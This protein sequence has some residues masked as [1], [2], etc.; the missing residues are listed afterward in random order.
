MKNQT[1]FAHATG[2]TIER[3]VW[4]DWRPAVTVVF[5][6]GNFSH[7]TAEHCGEDSISMQDRPI[8]HFEL[9]EA[10]LI[11]DEEYKRRETERK[12]KEDARREEYDRQ[13]YARLKAKYES[14]P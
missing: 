6:D 8:G 5:A 9:K 3:V 14:K 11:T 1:N 12:A 7:I 2:K 4:Y 13:Q 10:G